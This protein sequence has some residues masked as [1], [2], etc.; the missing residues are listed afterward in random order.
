M[1]EFRGVIFIYDKDMV[2]KLKS[3]DTRKKNNRIKRIIK[4][5]F[6]SPYSMIKNPKIK[7][8]EKYDPNFEPEYVYLLKPGKTRDIFFGKEFMETIFTN[9]EY[10]NRLMMGIH[11]QFIISRD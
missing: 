9:E 3:M 5:F 1:A 7:V 2:V 6:E 8:M 10:H 11:K 4:D